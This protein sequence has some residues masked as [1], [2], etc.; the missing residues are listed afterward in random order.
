[1]RNPFWLY[2]RYL[3]TMR[4]L[5][6]RRKSYSFAVML[7]SAMYL[8]PAGSLWEAPGLGIM[9]NLVSRNSGGVNHSS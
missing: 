6:S 9:Q 8:H 7:I 1:M 3:S 4:S 5:V 2:L